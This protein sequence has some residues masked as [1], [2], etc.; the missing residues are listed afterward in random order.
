MKGNRALFVL[1]ERQRFNVRNADILH[2]CCCGMNS[3]LSTV[4]LH[5]SSVL[6]CM[7]VA[8]EI[9]ATKHLWMDIKAK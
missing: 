9:R 7:Y 1:M 5:S 3:L 6:S 4:L 8:H 2:T